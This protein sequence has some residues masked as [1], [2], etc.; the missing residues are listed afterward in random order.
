MPGHLIHTNE[1]LV[2]LGEN[3]F[4]ERSAVQARE[5]VARRLDGETAAAKRR[6]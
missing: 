5:I 6:L 3:Y 2:L 4:V 1:I